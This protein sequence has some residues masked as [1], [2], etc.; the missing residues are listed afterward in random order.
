MNKEIDGRQLHPPEPL[1]LTLAAL[2]T[3][4][5]DDELRLLIYCQPNPLFEI[6][7]KTGYVWTE[8]VWKDGTHEILIR[9]NV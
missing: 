7:R 9:R 1:T 6:L 4:R 5:D 3:L 8:N 2:E